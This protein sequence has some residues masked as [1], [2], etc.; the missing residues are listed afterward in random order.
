MIN[1]EWTDDRVQRMEIFIEKNPSTKSTHEVTASKR[2]LIIQ[3]DANLFQKSWSGQI[4]LR[5]QVEDIENCLSSIRNQINQ[6]KEETHE[7][8]KIQQAT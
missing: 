1:T 8:N 6:T 3:W 5:L 4:E 2:L 7:R